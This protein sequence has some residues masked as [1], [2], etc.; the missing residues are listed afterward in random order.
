MLGN[1][2]QAV[3]AA[4]V[5]FAVNGLGQGLLSGIVRGIGSSLI[6][7]GA[8]LTGQGLG[9]ASGGASFLKDL[10]SGGFSV[11]KDFLKDSL[12]G[13]LNQ[14]NP[15]TSYQK[16]LRSVTDSSLKTLSGFS[17]LIVSAT[18]D[19]GIQMALN[20]IDQSLEKS[21]LGSFTKAILSTVANAG[22]NALGSAFASDSP[23]TNDASLESIGS[24]GPPTNQSGILSKISGFFSGITTALKDSLGA[25]KS[26]FVG[27]NGL[28]PDAQ[29]TFN[30]QGEVDYYNALD[31]FLDLRYDIEPLAHDLNRAYLDDGE[32]FDFGLDP[33]T[34]GISFSDRIG[35]LFND[36][37]GIDWQGI[38]SPAEFV[39]RFDQAANIL[40]DPFIDFFGGPLGGGFGTDIF[41]GREYVKGTLD[42]LRFG[43]GFDNI[44]RSL[45]AAYQNGEFGQAA[46]N[47]LF[48]FLPHSQSTPNFDRAAL[49]ILTEGGRALSF[50]PLAGL[51]TKGVGAVG[52]ISQRARILASTIK[53]PYGTAVQDLSET[54][55]VARH[56]VQQGATLYRIG[57]TGKS[58]TFEAQFWSLENPSASN[59]AYGH[60]IPPR[61]I[62][63]M[64]FIE[65]ARLKRGTSFVTRPAPGFGAN[66][67]GSIE[68]VV[69]E[70]GVEGRTFHFLGFERKRRWY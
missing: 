33:S 58:R 55:L 62:R 25:I 20:K 67:G 10:K 28:S 64:D 24:R 26:I 41:L 42:A 48:P 61:N 38:H 13:F 36:L 21:K 66:K 49:G 63:N 23:F 60:G 31:D 32:F 70:G 5:R 65:T 56:K 3:G 15:I 11:V 2:V 59:F 4:F 22:L 68:V 6:H 50:L 54:A 16:L 29:I 47:L 51:A 69:S 18:K 1:F 46:L 45:K 17:K 19:L 8:G 39:D 37:Q 57:T 27:N 14:F 9:F 30:D 35:N 44:G 40:T 34:K 7:L 43:A 12:G 52:K 53:T